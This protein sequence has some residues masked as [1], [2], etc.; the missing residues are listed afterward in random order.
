MASAHLSALNEKHRKLEQALAD[1]LNHSSRDDQAI[2]RLKLQKLRIKEHIA[3][4]QGVE[5]TIAAA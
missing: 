3:Y 1:E 5:D 2:R 4:L